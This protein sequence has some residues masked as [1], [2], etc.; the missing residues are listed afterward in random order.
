MDTGETGNEFLQNPE[1]R[2][3]FQLLCC[4]RKT[5]FWSGMA[6]MKVSLFLIYGFAR[7]ERIK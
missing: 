2:K 5:R 4:N 7:L 1:I 6:L 3:C